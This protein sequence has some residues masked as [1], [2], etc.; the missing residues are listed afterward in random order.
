[1]DVGVKKNLAVFNS[2]L[3]PDDGVPQSLGPQVTLTGTNLID[4]APEFAPLDNYGG[5]TLTMPLLAGSPGIDGG[6]DSATNEFAT[7]QRG[8][9][10]LYGA[11]VDIGAVESTPAGLNS[12]TAQ[13]ICTNTAT[14]TYTIN[15]TATCI[16]NN[17]PSTVTFQ[18]GTLPY[19]GSASVSIPNS[20]SE[21][22]VSFTADFSRDFL[23]HWDVVV[24][25]DMG[26]V[27]SPDIQIFLPPFPMDVAG[28]LNGDG[29]VSQGELDQVYS[30]YLATSPYLLITNATGLGQSNVNFTVSNGLVGSYTVQVSTDLVNW[31]NLGPALPLYNFTDTN[32]PSA[33]QRY[34]RL[35][36]P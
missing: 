5:P 18:Y 12:L 31:V 13:I 16:L 11:H 25:N 32:A 28:D 24:S 15:F 23:V 2:I 27:S 36:Y 22:N 9:P 14:G 30:N 7:D 10:R 4:G 17:L 29:I 3:G 33:S 34:Y 8:Y 1:V 19:N 35:V 6:D 21:T 20:I 26:V